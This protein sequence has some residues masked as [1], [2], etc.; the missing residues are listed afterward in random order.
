MQTKISSF[1]LNMYHQ[2][3]GSA[4]EKVYQLLLFVFAASLSLTGAF[5][6]LMFFIGWWATSLGLAILNNSWNEP[7][8]RW[9]EMISTNGVTVTALGFM[10]GSITAVALA[11]TIMWS[12]NKLATLMLAISAKLSEKI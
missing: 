4:P 12:L 2:T 9:A 5:S 7:T 1:A 6:F 3:M 11:A 10:V 8:Q